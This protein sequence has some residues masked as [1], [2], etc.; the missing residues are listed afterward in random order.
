MHEVKWKLNNEWCAMCFF[1]FA[2]Y[3]NVCC[4]N[5]TLVTVL[6]DQCYVLHTSLTSVHAGQ[7]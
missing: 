7:C 1:C 3:A 4:V 5:F 6:V 2:M